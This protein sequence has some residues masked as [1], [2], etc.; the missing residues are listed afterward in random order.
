MKNGQYLICPSS[1]NSVLIYRRD[2]PQVF[3][4]KIQGIPGCVDS[5]VTKQIHS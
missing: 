5:I 2:N 4:D 1:E 3:V